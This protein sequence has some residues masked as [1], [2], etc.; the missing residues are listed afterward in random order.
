MDKVTNQTAL[1]QAEDHKNW[2]AVYAENHKDFLCT[3]K[4]QDGSAKA[5]PTAARSV[6]LDGITLRCAHSIAERILRLAFKHESQSWLD[7]PGTDEEKLGLVVGEARDLLELLDT[8]A[9]RTEA[10][11]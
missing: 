2:C 3:C 7:A 11:S 4:D 5:S 6:D 10:R 9:S 1:P 8:A